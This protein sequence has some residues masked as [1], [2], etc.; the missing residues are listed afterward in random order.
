MKAAVILLFSTIFPGIVALAATQP[1]SAVIYF[2]QGKWAVD[3]AYEHN[4]ARLDSLVEIMHSDSTRRITQVRVVGAASPEGSVGI[5]RRLSYHR[6]MQIFD[7]VNYDASMPDS[8][9]KFD[10]IGRDWTGLYREVEMDTEVPYRSEV[11][12]LL[13]DIIKSISGGQPDGTTNLVKLQQLRAGVPYR[14]LYIH[15]FPQLRAS[16]LYVSYR[17]QLPSLDLLPGNTA[18]VEW[19]MI[20]PEIPSL[21]VTPV[22]KNKPFY[23]ALKTNMLYDAALLPNIGAEFI[24]ARIGRL[25]PIGCMPGGIRTVVI[26]IG[27]PMVAM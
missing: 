26:A 2:H 7:Y 14:Y 9:V 27:E 11:L 3:G 24:L 4:Q 15:Q 12:Q 6:A 10:F 19:K 5:N 18:E 21:T 22:K 25:R 8:V 23:M 1:D 16:H 13:S 20:E 17:L